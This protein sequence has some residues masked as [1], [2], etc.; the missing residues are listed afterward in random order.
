M[1]ERLPTIS[2]EDFLAQ[3]HSRTVK[4]MVKIEGEVVDEYDRL[5]FA[6]GWLRAN[7]DNPL[8]NPDYRRHYQRQ[9]DTIDAKLKDPYGRQA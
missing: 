9:V 8:A 4:E 3:V 6:E 1:S 7:W 5:R 2:Y